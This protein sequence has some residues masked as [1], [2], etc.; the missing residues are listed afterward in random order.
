V[1]ASASPRRVQLL[2]VLGLTFQTDVSAIAENLS[3][4][5]D[6]ESLARDLALAKARVVSPRHP[7]QIVLAA[8]TLI[9]FRG[10]LMG[11]PLDADEAVAMLRS[12]RGAWHR[13][14]TGVAIINAETGE[15]LVAAEITRVLM[16]WYTDDEIA[17]YVAS[18]DPMDKAAA[19]AIQHRGF[20]PVEKLDICY[21]NVMGLPLC[22]TR[23]LLNQAGVALP[24]QGESLRSR[25][26]SFCRQARG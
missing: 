1:L 20:H 10:R 21:T 5:H 23:E 3:G 24:V 25:R 16:R 8:D 11:K 4:P 22:T 9:A 6:A 14:I 15:E 26:C 19:Y 7:R 12:L 17:A 18:G 13:V 2:A